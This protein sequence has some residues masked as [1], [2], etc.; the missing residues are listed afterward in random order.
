MTLAD[1]PVRMSDPEALF[2]AFLHAPQVADAIRAILIK[3][4]YCYI[5]YDPIDNTP[6]FSWYL[7]YEK[8]DDPHVLECI[9]NIIEFTKK[10][11]LGAQFL[12]KYYT[13][14]G[15]LVEA[16]KWIVSPN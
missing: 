3:D 12:N 11:H 5:R 8:N 1:Q 10:N 2:T 15:N 13:C 16:E 9:N 6:C 4:T 7:P 14:V